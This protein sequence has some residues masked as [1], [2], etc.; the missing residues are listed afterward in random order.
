[1]VNVVCCCERRDHRRLQSFTQLHP[2]MVTITDLLH[3][4]WRSCHSRRVCVLHRVGYKR[5]RHCLFGMVDLHV[6]YQP[7]SVSPCQPVLLSVNLWFQT[8]ESRSA[9]LIE[10]FASSQSV[11]V[12]NLFFSL[13]GFDILHTRIRIPIIS[14]KKTATSPVLS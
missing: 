14:P 7:I 10:N 9:R 12:I 8:L 1:M 4:W 5:L 11:N 3:S 13:G 6:C 2:F